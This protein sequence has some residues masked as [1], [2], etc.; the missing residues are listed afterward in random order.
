MK[1]PPSQAARVNAKVRKAKARVVL[2]IRVRP[3]Y[4]V[5]LAR[6]AKKNKLRS[7]SVAAEM[8]IDGYL[9]TMK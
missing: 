3:E 6:L 8:A 5:K 2:S 1:K 9:T 4:K 7:I